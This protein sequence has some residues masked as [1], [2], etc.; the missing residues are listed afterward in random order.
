MKAL[1]YTE[2]YHLKYVD[3]PEPEMAEDEVL[4]EVKACAICGSDVH[5]YTGTT[6][7]RL[8]PL[9]M[10][11]EAS[12]VI[13]GIGSNVKGWKKGD[14]VTFDSTISC[15]TCFFCQK[16]QIN[17]CNNRM[18]LGVSIPEYRRNGAFAEYV[19]VPKHILYALPEGLEFEKAAL[20]E[21]LSVAVH[22]INRTPVKEKDRI[23]VIGAGMIGLLVIQALKAYGHKGIIA[24]DND[25]ERL[26]LALKLGAETGLRSDQDDVPAQII[27]MT[28]NLGAD[29]VFEA[30]G[31]GPTVTI[32]ISSLRK[33]GSLSLIGNLAPTVEVNLQS[34]VTR[35]LS[36]YGS[37][38]SAGEYPACLDM[39]ASGAID[40]DTLISAVA[41]LS[42]GAEWFKRLY[43]REPGLMKVVLVPGK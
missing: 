1:L 30:V 8:P 23:V 32:A 41:P 29:V 4:V 18:V 19:V 13:A 40:M 33:G 26:K 20:V 6:G 7:R 42:E 25:P 12:G 9:I 43:D 27:K 11:H 34:I 3:Y 31:I 21:P 38:I 37:C 10:G 22:A 36:L 15:G 16:G 24:V 2:P 17:L 35:E 28:N 39:I 5:G 14:R